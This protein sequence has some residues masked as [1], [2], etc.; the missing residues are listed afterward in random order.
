M[1]LAIICFLG[2]DLDLELRNY[3]TLF[4][5]GFDIG[6]T[7]HPIAFMHEQTFLAC[8]KTE[9]YDLVH[10]VFEEISISRVILLIEELKNKHAIYNTVKFSFTCLSNNEIN[11]SMSH[12]EL[13]V[14]LTKAAKKQFNGCIIQHCITKTLT[15]RKQ[16]NAVEDDGLY[17]GRHSKL[18][19]ILNQTKTKKQ[20][21]AL[22][23]PVGIKI[24]DHVKFNPVDT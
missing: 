1:N 10:M 23:T 6:I 2:T 4:M 14:Q 5:R 8:H 18:K 3:T 15:S 11:T 24:L 21:Y 22:D 7:N 12:K 20:V 13:I 17:F 9:Y 16:C 19:R